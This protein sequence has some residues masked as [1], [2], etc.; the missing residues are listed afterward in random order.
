MIDEENKH[1]IVKFQTKIT[2]KYARA[3]CI[4]PS[5]LRTGVTHSTINAG[6]H[7]NL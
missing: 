7:Y 3:K 4:H 6:P 2:V 1:I 5:A